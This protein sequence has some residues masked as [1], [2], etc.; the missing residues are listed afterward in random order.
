LGYL[1]LI[2]A[3]HFPSYSKEQALALLCGDLY[4]NPAKRGASGNPFRVWQAFSEAFGCTIGIAGN[5]DD[6]GPDLDRVKSL[7]RAH[8]LLQGT[9]VAQGLHVAGLS[10]IIGRPDKNFRLAEAVY[11]NRV[12][13]LLRQAPQLLLTHLS[14]GINAKGLPGEAQLTAV[15]TQGPR[16]LVLCGHSHWPSVEPQLLANGTQVLNA[17]GKVFIL[18]RA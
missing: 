4:A 13:T 5:H 16:T 18:T 3:I 6:F 1:D 7:H 9:A 10:G 8:F 15:L 2:Y 17:D 12:A 14:P 11:F